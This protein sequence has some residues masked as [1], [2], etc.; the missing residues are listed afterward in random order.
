MK[1][2]LVL[3]IAALTTVDALKMKLKNTIKQG[4]S[5]LSEA[6]QS[7]WTEEEKNLASSYESGEE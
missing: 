4:D 5:S 7:Q 2:T 1:F 3:A 6:D